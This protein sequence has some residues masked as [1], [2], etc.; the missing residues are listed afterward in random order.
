VGNAGVAAAITAVEIDLLAAAR[1]SIL[2]LQ[3][4]LDVAAAPPLTGDHH[5]DVLN[6]LE[7]EDTPG[8]PPPVKAAPTAPRMPRLGLPITPTQKDNV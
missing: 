2:T 6:E 3:L 8:P 1:K 7:A 5:V 4:A